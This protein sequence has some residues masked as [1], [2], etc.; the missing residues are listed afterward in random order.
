AWGGAAEAQVERPQQRVEPEEDAA[1]LDPVLRVV[2]DE[3][4]ADL[5]GLE[6][7]TAVNALE[8]RLA[9]ELVGVHEAAELKAVAGERSRGISRQP[10]EATPLEEIVLG[11]SR[12]AAAFSERQ[13]DRERVV[14]ER[15]RGI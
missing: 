8:Q 15:A 14:A 12:V 11:Q 7:E 10:Q 4:S 5:S 1:C 6:R 13:R 2:G 3:R 9:R